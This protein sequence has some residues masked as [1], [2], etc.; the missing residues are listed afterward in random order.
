MTAVTGDFSDFN[1]D[2]TE[3]GR[4]F[5]GRIKSNHRNVL[6]D[7]DNE[8][9]QNNLKP[10]G[11]L[12]VAG[13]YMRNYFGFMSALLISICAFVTPILFIVLPRLNINQ[14]WQLNEC[15]LECEG[16]LI[17]IAFKLFILLLG[18][19]AIYARK[20]S[21]FLPRVYEM[22]ALLI[23]LLFI[24]TFSFWLFYGVRIIDTRIQDYYKI[25]QFTV[26]YVDVLLFIFVVSVFII[27]LRQL[28]PQY[29]VKI[30]NYLILYIEIFLSKMF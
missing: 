17:G 14:Q 7:M 1:D 19:W 4:S 21:A 25:L 27:E 8:S 6:I 3:D 28:Q 29:V 23:F 12:N 30:G 15:G 26:S 20:P 5:H 16:L 24:M 9:L 22:R 13:S 2:V 10:S 18:S 11:W